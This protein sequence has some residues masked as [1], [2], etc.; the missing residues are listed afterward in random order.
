M[1]AEN[2]ARAV[3]NDFVL[4][5]FTLEPSPEGLRYHAPK[6]CVTSETIAKLRKNKS[7][8]LN[9]LNKRCPFCKAHGVRQKRHIQEGLIYIDTRC[10][11]CGDLVEC[12]VPAEQPFLSDELTQA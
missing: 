8:L 3:L 5:G 11:N 9:Y 2:V 10:L 12:Y 7:I 4:L 1:K 6:E